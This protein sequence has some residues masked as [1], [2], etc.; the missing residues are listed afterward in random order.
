MEGHPDSDCGHSKDMAWLLHGEGYV[1]VVMP[2]CPTDSPSPL[3]SHSLTVPEEE[4]Q[5][6]R[7][8]S[9]AVSFVSTDAGEPGAHGGP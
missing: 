7:S 9:L 5:T 2:L 6:Q 1:W 4:T 3:P 8:C